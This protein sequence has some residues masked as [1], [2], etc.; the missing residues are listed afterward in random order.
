M[1]VRALSTITAYGEVRE[2]GDEFRVYWTEEEGRRYESQ[3]IV[4]VL[5]WDGAP[6]VAESA[7]ETSGV[8]GESLTE[9]QD[10]L[11]ACLLALHERVRALED[12]G[13]SPDEVEAIR[14]AMGTAGD[15]VDTSDQSDSSD[16]SDAEAPEVARA[17]RDLIDL[18][19]E[20]VDIG[21]HLTDLKVDDLR[22]IANDMEIRNLHGKMTKATLI[23]L[24]VTGLPGQRA[25]YAARTAWE[26]AQD[27]DGAIVRDG[28]PVV[29][30]GGSS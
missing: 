29:P 10:R 14:V 20:G 3:G 11:E 23:D 25:Q 22:A 7:P 5:D 13:L 18:E 28:V 19:D 16:G 4:L 12:R 27:G 1:L 9:R 6:R 21:A 15:A 17:V 8:F 2:K 30:A 26:D 24:I